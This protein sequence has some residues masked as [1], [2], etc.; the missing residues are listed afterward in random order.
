MTED[1]NMEGTD[2]NMALFIFFVPVSKEFRPG[3]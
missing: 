3:N 2:Y 1:L